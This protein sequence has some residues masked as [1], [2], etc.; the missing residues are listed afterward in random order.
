MAAARRRSGYFPDMRA[1]IRSLHLVGA[2]IIAILMAVWFSGALGP[3][4]DALLR[5]TEGLLQ[6]HAVLGKL[7]FTV[8]AGAAAMLAFVS[9]AVLV[10]AATAAWGT[11]TTLFLL[12]SGWILGGIAAYSVGRW[13]GRGVVHRFTSADKLA[14]YESR[15][16]RDVRWW[17]L[18]LL[19]LGLPSEIPG[20]LCGILRVRFR[21][22]LAA[23]ALG[24]V[25]YALAS[26]YLGEAFLQR[27][28]ALF[29]M[30]FIAGAVFFGL[31]F[32]MLRRRLDWQPNVVHNLDGPDGQPVSNG[33]ASAPRTRPLPG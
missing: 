22:Y 32:A 16:Q 20:Y 2:V 3:E 15:V 25:P 10:P 4:V 1:R 21:L 23:V 14:W 28:I 27:N 13:L 17:M 24:E 6:E 11:T 12:W 19:Q 31:A 5:R 18:L 30:I 8:L 33:L 26:V 7:L 29:A 9:S